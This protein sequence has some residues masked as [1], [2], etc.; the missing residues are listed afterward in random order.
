MSDSKVMVL[1]NVINKSEYDFRDYKIIRLK[2][3]LEALIVHDPAIS[4]K[5]KSEEENGKT[6]L[7]VYFSL[8]SP[9]FSVIVIA[10][11]YTT[12]YCFLDFLFS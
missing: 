5:H 4:S 3:G 11:S 8:H 10:A 6:K 12:E 7:L 9:T 1:S 2:N